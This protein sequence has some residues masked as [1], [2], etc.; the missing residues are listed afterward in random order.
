MSQLNAHTHTAYSSTVI[1][2]YIIKI[3]INITTS[4]HQKRVAVCLDRCYGKSGQT[5]HPVSLSGYPQMSH[6]LSHPPNGPKTH[7]EQILLL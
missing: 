3:H 1:Y 7:W 5:T 2:I 6:N 4:T